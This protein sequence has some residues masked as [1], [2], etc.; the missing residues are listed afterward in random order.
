M[1]MVSSI[2]VLLTDPADG[3]C[4]AGA[5]TV[6]YSKKLLEIWPSDETWQDVVSD[7][8]FVVNVADV[9]GRTS[10]DPKL[11]VAA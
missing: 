11:S 7:T 5:D 9:I 2:C 1:L 6:Q 8:P 10:G 4:P 3:N